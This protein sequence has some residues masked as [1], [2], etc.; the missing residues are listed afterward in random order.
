[1]VIGVGIEVAMGTMVAG[2]MVEADITEVG[3]TGAKVND[4]QS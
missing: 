3:T 4:H 1:M 2:I